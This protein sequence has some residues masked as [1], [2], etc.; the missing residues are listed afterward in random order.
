[1]SVSIFSEV[2]NSEVISY[3]DIDERDAAIINY[4]LIN[5]HNVTMF[6]TGHDWSNIIKLY[7]KKTTSFKDHVK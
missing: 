7:L 4:I 2:W 6:R 5:I 1:M 3:K